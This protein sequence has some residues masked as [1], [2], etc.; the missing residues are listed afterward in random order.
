MSNLKMIK[1]NHLKM[2][3]YT[4]VELMISLSISLFV[5][6]AAVSFFSVTSSFGGKYIEQKLLRSQLNLLVTRL[7]DDIARAGFCFNC[8]SLNPYILGDMNNTASSILLDDSAIKHS[9][10]CIRF[11]YN[12]DKRENPTQIDKDDAKGYRL[13]KDPNGKLALEIYENRKGLANWHC[14]GGYWQDISHYPLQIEALSFTRENFSVP[15]SNNI[16]QNIKLNITASLITDNL[17]RE[18][19]SVTINVQNLDG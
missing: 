18:S 7:A 11:S 1:Y 6:G 10:D 5:L 12:H 17:I 15:N 16:L 14:A 4:L 13:G 9:G 8:T 2:T 3:G 19:Q